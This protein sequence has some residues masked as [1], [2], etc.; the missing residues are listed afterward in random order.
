MLQLTPQME[1]VA[2]VHRAVATFIKTILKYHLAV[3]LLYLCIDIVF[4][5]LNMLK[6]K[7]SKWKKKI[8]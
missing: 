3:S 6:T 8:K 7:N 1:T 4:N 2:T 5:K